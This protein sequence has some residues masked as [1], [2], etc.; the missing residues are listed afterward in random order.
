MA[1]FIKH[2]YKKMEAFFLSFMP[3][4]LQLEIHTLFSRVT[5]KN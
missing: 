3:D 4:D 2:K 1:S 5:Q